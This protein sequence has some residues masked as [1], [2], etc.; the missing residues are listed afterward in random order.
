MSIINR[1]STIETA[2]ERMQPS[3]PE[4]NT[5]MRF[6]CAPAR[7]VSGMRNPKSRTGGR[8]IGFSDPVP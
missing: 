5:N 2:T 4:K 7:G 6:Y 1:L 8:G 3:L